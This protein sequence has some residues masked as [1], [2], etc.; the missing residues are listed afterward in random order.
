M[1]HLW[2]SVLSG[3]SSNIVVSFSD[4]IT[5]V[6]TDHRKTI[7]LESMTFTDE[8]TVD[9]NK[10]TF[11]DYLTLTDTMTGMSDT[12]GSGG[13]VDSLGFTDTFS[14]SVGGAVST[15]DGLTINDYFIGSVNQN[16]RRYTPQQ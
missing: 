13:L 11:Q 5:F 2:H 6:E 7:F 4:E 8:F 1:L 15:N 12:E 9:D 16:K 3:A 10:V 14:A